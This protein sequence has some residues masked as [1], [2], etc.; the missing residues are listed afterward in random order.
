[1]STNSS[2]DDDESVVVEGIRSDEVDKDLLTEKI[3]KKEKQLFKWAKYLRRCS[4]C[5]TLIAL[6]CMIMAAKYLIFQPLFP[7]AHLE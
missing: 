6:S 4:C 5:L 7:M 2:L 3:S 1:M